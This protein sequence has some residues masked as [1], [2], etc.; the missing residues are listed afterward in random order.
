MPSVRKPAN[1]LRDRAERHV[2][3]LVADLPAI[4][5]RVLALLELAGADRD[6]AARDTGLDEDALRTAAASARRALRRTRKPLVSGA[7][8]DRAELLISDRLDTTLDRH[9]RKW[10]EIHVARCP[11]CEEHE[12]LLAEAREELRT[13]FLSEP[14]ALPPAPEP[15]ALDEGAAKLRLVPPA[16]N[17]IPAPAPEP[18]EWTVDDPMRREVSTRRAEA[19]VAKRPRRSLSPSPAAKRAARILAILLVI[20]GILAGLGLGLSAL[21]GGDDHPTAPWSKPGAPD[22]RPAP[23]SAQ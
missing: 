12:T 23:L 14:K 8:C 19:V 21:G 9:A 22:I 1:E 16:P 15:P 20:A 3:D 17:D 7:R 5:R 4:E 2:F 13:T 11:R 18:I 10:L 6:A